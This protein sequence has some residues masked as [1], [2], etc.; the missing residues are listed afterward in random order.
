MPSP[1]FRE[2]GQGGDCVDAGSGF[3]SWWSRVRRTE[4]PRRSGRAD[5][6]DGERP[7][8][9]RRV[10][11]PGNRAHLDRRSGVNTR[12]RVPERHRGGV[13]VVGEAGAWTRRDE[14]VV[15]SGDWLDLVVADVSTPAGQRFSQDVVRARWDQAACIVV[16]EV[17]QVML[18]WRHR[19]I[20]DRWGWELPAGGV[21]RDDDLGA[22]ITRRVEADCGWSIEGPRLVWSVPQCPDTTDRIGHL[23]WARAGQCIGPP[24]AEAVAQVGWF[25][26]RQLRQVM[27]DAVHDTFTVAALLWLFTRSVGGRKTDGM[28]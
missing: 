9:L 26:L 14:R 15:W 17:H 20:T 28:S 2:R 7:R 11:P 22:A 13:A 27:G 12:S 4:R 3:L 25:D 21:H 16:N 10:G 24:D 23:V 6:L 8:H 1:T 19:Y 18:V 5:V